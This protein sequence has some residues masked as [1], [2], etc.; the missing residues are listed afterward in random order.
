LHEESQETQKEDQI[1]VDG[2]YENGVIIAK[3]PQV[4]KYDPENMTFSVDVALNGQQFT[5]KPVNFRFYDIHI[6][7]VEPELGP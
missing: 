7:K 1:C 6:E 4:Q 3:V 2:Y 5:G